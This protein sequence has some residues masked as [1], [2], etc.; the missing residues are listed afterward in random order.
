MKKDSLFS[1]LKKEKEKKQKK[2][3]KKEGLRLKREIS[4]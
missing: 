1:L 2:I 3:L 4:G